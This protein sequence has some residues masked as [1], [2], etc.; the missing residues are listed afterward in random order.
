[1]GKKIAIMLLA[2]LVSLPLLAQRPKVGVVLSGG[3]AKGSAHVGVLKYLEENNIPIDYIA[4]TSMGAIIGGLYAIG[5]S[6]DDLEQMINSQD[7]P[8]VMSGQVNR[9]NITYENREYQDRVLLS[10]PFGIHPIKDFSAGIESSILPMGLI[11]DQHITNLFSKYTVGYQDS[12]DFNKMPIPYACVAVDLDTKQEV[13][14]H[15]GVLAKAMRASMSIPGV[16]APVRMGEDVFVD[17][18]VKNNFPVDVAKEMGA[19]IIIGSLLGY[20]DPHEKATY[21]T[22]LDVASKMLDM[23]T[24]Q[25]IEEGVAVTDILISPSVVGYNALSFDSES[26]KVLMQNGYD[27]AVRK[28]TE[29][30]ELKKYLD[31]WDGPLTAAKTYKKA[32]KPQDTIEIAALVVRGIPKDDIR[33]LLDDTKIAP[34]V[35]PTID[36]IDNAIDDLYATEAFTSINYSLVGKE[37]PFNLELEFNPAPKNVAGLGARFD[38]QEIASLLFDFRFNHKKLYGSR[39]FLQAKLHNNFYVNAGYTYAFK[40]R[41]EVGASAGIKRHYFNMMDI[42]KEVG[43]VSYLHYFGKVNLST[44]RLKK[45]KINAGGRIDIYTY[46]N[47][48]P[49]ISYSDIYDYDNRSNIFPGVYFSLDFDNTDSP[50]I[51]NRGVSLNWT[52]RLYKPVAVADKSWFS[53]HNLS[54]S[55]A[56]TPCEYV[57]VLPFVNARLVLGKNPPVIAANVV[58]GYQSGKF[59]SQQLPFYG[60]LNPIIVGKFLAIGGLDL[61]GNIGQAHHVYLGGNYAFQGNDVKSVLEQDNFWGVRLGYTFNSKAGPLSFNVHYSDFTRKVGVYISLGYN[62]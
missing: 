20:E 13:V 53:L 56:W 25:K 10:V 11:G 38:T 30:E 60:I 17:G 28:K 36:N 19:D 31:K 50:A 2:A 58:G 15:S 43:N 40:S 27:A 47:S 21:N 39:Y 16:F 37:S 26:L 45:V 22:P 42:D 9:D 62:F 14:F 44:S 18:G 57:T 1:M 48:F 23:I 8:F 6:A 4:G 54:F 51:P 7:W 33:W 12:L 35:R 46:R 41:F 24:G 32:L 49:I 52:S 61:R 5:Y 55:A 29:I 3:G 34:G 59:M